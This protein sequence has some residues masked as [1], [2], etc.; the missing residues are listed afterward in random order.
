MVTTGRQEIDA[1][2][3]V[4]ACARWF[5]TEAAALTLYARQWLDGAAAEDVVQEVFVRLLNQPCLPAQVR[6]WL[7]RSVRNGAISDLRSRRRRRKREAAV[8][9]QRGDWF[10][11][12]PGDLID[13]DTVQQALEHLPGDQREIVTLRIWGGLT[14][15]EIAAV[16]GVSASTVSRKHRAGLKAI[17]T[18]L[19]TSC[20]T[21]RT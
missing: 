10:Q 14:L 8:A 11:R 21:N 9:R 5:E 20:R 16:V 15:D 6:P 18:Q 4:P 12:Q 13:A 19:E 17:R 3:D 1:L 2:A 7:Y